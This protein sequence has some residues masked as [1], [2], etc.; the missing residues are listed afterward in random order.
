MAALA[1]LFAIHSYRS[2][3]F[4]ILDEEGRC[5]LTLSNPRCNR[6]ALS[7]G[8]RIMMFLLSS[9]AFKTNLRR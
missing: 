4:F 2:S 3:P 9:F 5:S 1:L 6:L 7:T 8:N